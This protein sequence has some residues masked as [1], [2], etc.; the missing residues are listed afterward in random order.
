MSEELTS[1]IREKGVETYI[2]EEKGDRITLSD[3]SKT[4]TSLS[5]WAKTIPRG[6][7][8]PSRSTPPSSGRRALFSA[9]LRMKHLDR[10]KVKVVV[11]YKD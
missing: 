2:A 5:D 6:A 4:E 9:P 1:F 3:D 8:S 11:S 10:T 7:S